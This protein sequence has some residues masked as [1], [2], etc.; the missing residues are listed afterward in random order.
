MIA[1]AE[2]SRGLGVQ[3]YDLY[4]NLQPDSVLIINTQDTYEKDFSRYKGAWVTDFRDGKLSEEFV[5]DWMKDLDVVVSIET[6]YDWNLLDWAKET[7]TK[8][9]LWV[10]PEFYKPEHSADVLWNSTSW[11]MDALP[12]DTRIVPVPV[13][14]YGF[15]DLPDISDSI[16][17]LHVC[18]KPAL[19]DRNGTELVANALRRVTG[20]FTFTV[21]V[22][23][24]QPAGFDRYKVLFN[25]SFEEMYLNK[26]VL[27]LPRRYGGNSLPVLEAIG[28]GMA[29]VMSDISPNEDWPIYSVPAQKS[30]EIS[31]P[32]GTVRLHDA[33]PIALPTAIQTLINDRNSLEKYMS[34]SR[35]YAEENSWC[36]RRQFF[37]DELEWASAAEFKQSTNR[38]NLRVP[39]LRTTYPPDLGVFT[40]KLQ[41]N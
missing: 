3:S 36:S 15:V 8:T 34:L 29:V 10:N 30:A 18:G 28:H 17:F 20:N 32:C 4:A 14:N 16:N 25:P 9:I 33:E 39:T 40:R 31:M 22:Q 21:T 35:E 27:V 1:R 11:R 7:N 41:R 38:S 13:T 12:S 23:G 2:K 37:Y 24:H 6:F 19:R 26:H 5:K